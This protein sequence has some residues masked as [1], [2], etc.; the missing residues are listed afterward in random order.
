MLRKEWNIKILFQF[1]KLNL[2]FICLIK[3][4]IMAYRQIN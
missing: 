2:S 4:D 1:Q 3:C